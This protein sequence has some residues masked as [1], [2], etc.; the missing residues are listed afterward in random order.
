[1][2]V[3]DDASDSFRP[4]HLLTDPGN[5]RI[6]VVGTMQFQTVIQQR[7]ARLFARR[8]YQARLFLADLAQARLGSYH[9][10]RRQ[11]RLDEW[12]RRARR[13]VGES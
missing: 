13:M 8:A 4:I 9:W 10:Q 6:V 12:D 5:T 7:E 3:S 2:I 1:M 11:R